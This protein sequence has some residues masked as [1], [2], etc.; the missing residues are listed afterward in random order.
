MGMKRFA[1]VGATL[2]PM[3]VPLICRKCFLS[4]LKLLHFRI[5]SNNFLKYRIGMQQLVFWEEFF[6]HYIQALF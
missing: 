3:A 1:Y 5:N 2:V 6:L 4:N